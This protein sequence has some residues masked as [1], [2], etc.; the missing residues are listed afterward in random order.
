MNYW[1]GQKP[2]I[3]LILFDSTAVNNF[4]INI[5]V[6]LSFIYLAAEGVPLVR[7]AEEDD[8]DT[9]DT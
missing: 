1:I 8:T 3:Y 2:S 7:A 5:A 9:S 4:I 6:I